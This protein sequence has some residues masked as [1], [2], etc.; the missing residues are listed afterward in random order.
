M[1]K[2]I[3]HLAPP[4]PPKQIIKPLSDPDGLCLRCAELIAQV[5]QERHNLTVKH[6]QPKTL[7]SATQIASWARSIKTYAATLDDDHKAA[8]QAVYRVV[9]W[10]AEH[11]S[12]SPYIPVV[13]SAKSLKDKFD[14]LE[15]AMQ[16]LSPVNG[17]DLTVPEVLGKYGIRLVDS[18]ARDILRPAKK[19]GVFDANDDI[20]LA[21]HLAALY[22]AIRTARDDASLSDDLKL[23]LGGPSEIVKRYIEW[24]H[25]KQW[26]VS[27]K[28]L[29]VSSPAFGQ[30]RRDY[31]D[32]EGFDP[33]DGRRA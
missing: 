25:D 4:K 8:C 19:L 23:R 7:T 14:R 27:S 18:F 1:A 12:D 15:A 28:V 32:G 30:F 21:G 33:I 5:R 6:R 3:R 9:A 29:T 11:W 22:A 24:L 26:R 20:V 2:E 31:Q 10:Y 16:R 17:H 13:S